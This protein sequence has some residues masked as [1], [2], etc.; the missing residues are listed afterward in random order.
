[1]KVNFEQKFKEILKEESKGFA[2][3]WQ[4]V[5]IKSIHYQPDWSSRNS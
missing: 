1:M 5:E 4:L 2:I 3:D